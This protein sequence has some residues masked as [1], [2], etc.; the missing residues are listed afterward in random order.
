MFVVY[1]HTSLSVSLFQTDFD[2]SF[3]VSTV[4]LR[5]EICVKLDHRTTTQQYT[6]RM[7]YIN[8]TNTLN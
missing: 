6:K 1:G 5:N 3:Y 7:F 2:N 4:I 8:S